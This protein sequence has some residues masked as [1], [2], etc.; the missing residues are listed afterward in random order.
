MTDI[1]RKLLGVVVLLA[2]LAPLE[3]TTPVSAQGTLDGSGCWPAGSLSIDGAQ[4]TWPSPPAT[5]IDPAGSYQAK[6][7][8]TAGDILIQL[9][10]AG[11][12]LATNNFV[13]LALAGYFSGTDFHR[14]FADTLIQGGDP[15]ATGLGGP[16]YTI[17]SDPTVG[18]YPIGSVSMANSLPLLRK[19]PPIDW[20]LKLLNDS[21]TGNLTLAAMIG[22]AQQAAPYWNQPQT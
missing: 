17:P 19:A 22:G 2:M 6:L 8:T 5:I 12:P 9:D 14:I 11:A 7:Q 3:I 10:P 13:C 16:G 4:M 20:M 1:L 18:S 15:T 21:A